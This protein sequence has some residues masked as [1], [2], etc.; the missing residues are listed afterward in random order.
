MVNL[1]RFFHT[2]DGLPAWMWLLTL[3][4]T[5]YG[6]VLV[7]LDP[8]GADTALGTLLL[9]QML[10]ASR[11][12]TSSAAAGHFDP[13]LV[14]ERRSH[15]A[16]AHAAHATLVVALPWMVVGVI[17]VVRSTGSARAFEPGR[18]SAFAF[19]S[20]AAWALSL[21][22]AR[23]VAGSVWLALIIALATTN[24]GLE[25]YS[26]LLQ[27]SEG[28]TQL[29]HALAFAIACPFVMLDDVM[30]MREEVAAGLAVMTI[31]AFA[32]GIG[33]IVRRDYP[34]EPSV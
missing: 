20:A 14:R 32:A 27:R 16:I 18:V 15:I 28:F 1:L 11:G 6:A 29:A 13:L 34:L 23:L 3:V 8:A 9:W 26:L 24:V 25:Q 21:P 33:F 31:A 7:W 19:V 4:L 2:V 17:E 12:F 30:P 10:V 22:I 5:L